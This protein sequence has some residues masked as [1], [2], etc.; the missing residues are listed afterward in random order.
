MEDLDEILPLIDELEV[1]TIRK[2]SLDFPENLLV[3][4]K[5]LKYQNALKFQNDL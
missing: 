2:F 1:S 3:L 4:G 5:L